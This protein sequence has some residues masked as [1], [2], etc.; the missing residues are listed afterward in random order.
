MRIKKSLSTGLIVALA[1]SAAVSLPAAASTTILK[2][3]G[4]WAFQDDSTTDAGSIDFA[5]GLID[6]TWTVSADDDYAVDIKT[7]ASTGEYFKASTPIGAAFGA[8]GPTGT[9]NF[10]K[11]TTD[12]A[13]G[14]DGFVTITF[15]TPVAAGNL[16]I[17]ISDIDSDQTEISATTDGTTA[18]TTEQLK[19]YA[20]E[21]FSD[22][23][24]NF[25]VTRTNSPCSND[26]AVVPVTDQ[27]SHIVF[28]NMSDT[29]LWGTDG[30]SAWIRPSAAVKTITVRIIN[31]DSNAS[32]ERVWIAQ[33]GTVSGLAN[34]G[35]NTELSLEI[36]TMLVVAGLATSLLSKVRSRRKARHR[37]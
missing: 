26:T 8:N 15:A 7:V 37:A 25:C 16:A 24:F 23:S 35:I 13:D 3:W 29:D 4:N 36:A 21:S 11:F 17:A 32:S 20:G 19:G 27:T 5:S 34:T 2:D 28:G 33:K 30:A 10:L 9:N 22:L 14:T 1:T 31:G 12:P 6:A 18:L